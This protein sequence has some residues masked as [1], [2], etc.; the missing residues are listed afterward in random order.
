M[1]TYQH[2][3]WNWYEVSKNP[4]IDWDFIKDHKDLPWDFKDGVICN[5]NITLEIIEA[6]PE[7]PW[8]WKDLAYNPNFKWDWVLRYPTKPWDHDE[9]SQSDG[10]TI[11]DIANYPDE[12][13]DW[14]SLSMMFTLDDIAQYVDLDWDWGLIIQRRDTTHLKDESV[15]II[16]SKIVERYG[17]HLSASFF[18]SKRFKDAVNASSLPLAEILDHPDF[19]PVDYDYIS[20]FPSLTFEILKSKPMARWNWFAVLQNPAITFEMAESII[21]E[22]NWRLDYLVSSGK[23]S[24]AYLLKNNKLFYDRRHYRSR[25]EP[26]LH[27]F[28]AKKIQRWWLSIYYNPYHRVGR[29]KVYRDYYVHL[30]I[31]AEI[32]QS[33]MPHA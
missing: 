11:E 7:W 28:A 2:E 31:L 15:P 9:I 17:E 14:Y 25:Y 30:Q 19:Q 20:T 33:R 22:D 24:L 32:N 21:G 5:P 13:W 1:V 10:L 6:N 8:N 12:D 18:A 4:V 3:K 27:A 26:D 23:M 29:A 16:N